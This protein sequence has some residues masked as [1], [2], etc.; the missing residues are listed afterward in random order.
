DSLALQQFLS[1][2]EELREWIEEKMIRAQDE[3][4]RDA[5]TI[6]SKFVRHQAF[7]SELQSNKE[8]LEQLQTAATKLVDDK[9]EFHGTIDPHISD[10]ATQWEQLE[11][12][13]EEKGQKLFDANRQQLYV[14]SISDMKEWAQSLEQQMVSEDTAQDLTTVNVA[15]QKQ[16][17]I[18]SEMVKRSAQIDSLQQMEP[19]LEEMHPDEVEQIK[20]HRLAV[21][22]QL[23]RLQAPLDD[24]RK[25]LERKKAAFQFGRDVEDEK[26]WISERM[27][28][29]RARELGE[30][31]F[32]CHRLQKN[33]Q[34]LRNEIDNHEPWIQKICDNGRE[35]IEGG[36]ENSA[37]F[38][39]KINE[40]MHAWQELKDAVDARKARLADSELGH[41]F[42]Y[43][44]NEAEAWMSEQE[45]YMMQDER[46]K[47][48]FS[49][50][51]QIK[52][53]ERL[54]Q[55]INAYADTIRELGSRA[56]HFVDEQGPL[57]DQIAVRQSQIDKLYAGL[58]DLCRER[59]KR[60]DETLQL[61][62]LHR[63]ID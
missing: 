28:L 19:H 26:L 32:D 59:R 27:P 35:L 34:T 22:E 42:L 57:S 25:Q 51:N 29:A 60:L 11:K 14:Q 6:T 21:Q 31:L 3:T 52:K 53:H 36:H 15:M 8:R 12:T 9:P 39:L 54:Q 58:Q 2:C 24:R 47:D 20:A 50:Q 43:D 17:M 41:Q 44:C 13:T 49:T 10:L 63:E 38:E 33:T 23:Q 16:Q 55:D 30:S 37:A 45:L 62:G 48:E 56:R 18:E 5:K 7:Q 61:Y 4:Y 46:G 40:L 1:D